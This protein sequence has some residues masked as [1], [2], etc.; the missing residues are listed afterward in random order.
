MKNCCVCRREFTADSVCMKG[1]C[2]YRSLSSLLTVSALGSCV[3]RSKSSLLLTVSIWRVL[4]FTGARGHCWLCL[5]GGFLCL[6]EPE[7]TAD[8]VCMEGSC[9]NRSQSSLLL[10]VSTW[11]VLVFTGA[12]VHCWQCLHGGFLWILKWS[13]WCDW[14]PGD[15]HSA[16]RGGRHW[17]WLQVWSTWC[18]KTWEFQWRLQW[19]Q[20]TRYCGEGRIW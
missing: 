2:V 15:H 17:C 16:P 19:D 14:H 3:Y 13:G 8:C 10:T 18:S 12:R 11:R 5:Y 9:V 4:V 20:G 1:S 7:V 6:Q